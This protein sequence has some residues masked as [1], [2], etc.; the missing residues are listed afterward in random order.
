M[1]I[2]TKAAIGIGVPLGI[3]VVCIVAGITWASMKKKKLR[4]A[5]IVE[6]LDLDDKNLPRHQQL[7]GNHY[8]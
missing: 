1:E 8:A 7:S 2:G 3:F 6:E 4:K 5:G